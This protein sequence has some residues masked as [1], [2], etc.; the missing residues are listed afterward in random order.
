MSLIR[1]GRRGSR[2]PYRQRV[3][4]DGAPKIRKAINR[5]AEKGL[6]RFAIYMVERATIAFLTGESGEHWTKRQ[7]HKQYSKKSRERVQSVLDEIHE[8]GLWPWQ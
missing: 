2:G 8:A 1:R 4:K 7:F 3:G 6:S 5:A